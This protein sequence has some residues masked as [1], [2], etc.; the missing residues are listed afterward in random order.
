MGSM[1]MPAAEPQAVMVVQPTAPA[2]NVPA[3][4]ADITQVPDGPQ[5]SSFINLTGG[6]PDPE[7]LK[8]DSDNYGRALEGQLKKQSE[9]VIEEARIKKNMLEEQAKREIAQYQLQLEEKLKMAC[10]QVDKEAQ[11]QLMGLQEAAIA[12]KTQNEEESAIKSAT[13]SKAKAMEEMANKAKDI[14]KQ[15]NAAEA[16]LTAE[17]QAIMKAGSRAVVTPS[18]PMVPGVTMPAAA[19]MYAAPAPVAYAAPAPAMYVQ[20]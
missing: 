9:A 1:Y 4:A 12:R 20:Q 18:Q 19:P 13:Y 2:S 14:R 7:K 15:F 16:K 11:F 8:K 6:M 10:M 3:P 17:Y 5:A